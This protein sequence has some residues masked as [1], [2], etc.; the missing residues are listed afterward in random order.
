MHAWNLTPVHMVH[1]TLKVHYTHPSTHMT[2]SVILA[3]I[4]P[5][6]CDGNSSRN[7]ILGTTTAAGIVHALPPDANYTAVSMASEPSQHLLKLQTR[8]GANTTSAL[9]PQCI[10]TTYTHTHTQKKAA[11]E[12]LLSKECSHIM[13]TTGVIYSQSLC[14]L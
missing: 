9:S 12:P 3:G 6:W 2:R 1:T 5:V 13:Q 11:G 8:L 4:H 14:V 10:C 7:L